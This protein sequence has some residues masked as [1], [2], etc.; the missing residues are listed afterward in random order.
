VIFIVM[1]AARVLGGA[2]NGMRFSVLFHQHRECGEI[3]SA[4]KY[5][6][7]FKAC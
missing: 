5:G 4:D 1:K 3:T 2:L 7:M 6:D